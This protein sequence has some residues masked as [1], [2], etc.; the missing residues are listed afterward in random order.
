M[1]VLIVLLAS[2]LLLLV[3]LPKANASL[4]LLANT[5]LK[6]GNRK[7]SATPVAQESMFLHSMYASI[8]LQA[9][10]QKFLASTM[11]TSVLLAWLVNT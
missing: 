8:V 3:V 2:G 10:G 6:L 11:Q 4:V 7:M 9:G 1:C 5:L